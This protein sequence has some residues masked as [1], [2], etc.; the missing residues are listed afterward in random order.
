MAYWAER[1]RESRHALDEESLRAYFP[2][3]SVLQGL[4]DLCHRLFAITIRPC[5]APTGV[6][7][8]DVL[9]FEVANAA[10]AKI[11]AFYLDPYSRPADK[12]GGAWMDSC[13]DRR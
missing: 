11:A 4:F 2:F 12:Q 13:L 1:L 5:E 9:Y 10:G 6:W 7:H 8:P 3:P